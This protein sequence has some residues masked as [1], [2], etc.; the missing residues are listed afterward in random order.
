M[1]ALL[2]D[3]WLSDFHIDNTLAK[4]SYLHHDNGIDDCHVFLT[5]FDLDSIA[6]GYRGSKQTHAADKCKEFIEIENEII[7]GKI[8]SVTG[9]LHLPNHWTSLVIT[10]KPPRIF[11]GDSLG[12]PM[13]AIKVSFR[14]WICHMLGRSGCTIPESDISIYPLP[15]TYLQ[16]PYSC[17]PQG[18]SLNNFMQSGEEKVR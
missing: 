13:P 17:G 16:D 12:N 15:T 6:S 14:K 11:F 3:S 1:V 4:I 8:E 10:F 2:S 9:V 7:S 5:V 18:Y